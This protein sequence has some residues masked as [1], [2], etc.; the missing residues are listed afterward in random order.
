[1]IKQVFC[2]QVNDDHPRWIPHNDG[3]WNRRLS[4]PLALA[5][6]GS[7]WPLSCISIRIV[8]FGQHWVSFHLPYLSCFDEG[9]SE[10]RSYQPI[11]CTADES[12]T[13]RLHPS[14]WLLF[15]SAMAITRRNLGNSTHCDRYVG[16]FELTAIGRQVHL[17]VGLKVSLHGEILVDA[18]AVA[19]PFPGWFL[20]TGDVGSAAFTL[21]LAVH[22][23]SDIVLDCRMGPLRFLATVVAV[24]MFTIFCASV[25]V[26]MHPSD[27]YMRA[28]MWCWINE[29]RKHVDHG[30][31]LW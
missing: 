28:G 3:E 5:R 6:G 26:A 14:P 19:D 22:F 23:F 7:H 29:K 9:S 1:M 8:V 31:V 18:A 13:C 15:Q 16:I 4:L 25:G 12:F 10:D 27:F 17:L 24:W 21:T 11:C 30:L 20:N 2:L